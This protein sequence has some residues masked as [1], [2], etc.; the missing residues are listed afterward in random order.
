MAYPKQ[1]TDM[2][3]FRDH[4]V[5]CAEDKL[6]II[7]RLLIRL[8]VKRFGN[9]AQPPN[10]R[11][12]YCGIPRRGHPFAD[13]LVEGALL[14]EEVVPFGLGFLFAIGDE[15]ADEIADML[16]LHLIAF[17]LRR[18]MVDGDQLFG[19]LE[20]GAQHHIGITMFGCPDD[21]LRARRARDHDGGV[22]LLQR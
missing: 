22:R 18:L 6:V 11:D 13:L 1:V 3:Q 8:I 20:R 7:L 16:G 14:P 21:G 17:F 9:G 10:P 5:R 4:L 19:L 15:D 12:I 2:A